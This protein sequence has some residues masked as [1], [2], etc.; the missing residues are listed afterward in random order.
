MN[1]AV[2]QNKIA[3]FRVIPYFARKKID[4]PEGVLS[5]ID[6]NKT[7]LHKLQYQTN[8]T[9]IERDYLFDEVNLESDPIN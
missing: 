8:E 9:K 1:G 2:W 4:I 7:E 5:I 3:Q 6:L